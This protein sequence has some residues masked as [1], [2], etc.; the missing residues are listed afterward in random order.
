[1][2]ATVAEYQEVL[3]TEVYVDVDKLRQVSRHGIPTEVRG[4]V[5]K[6]LLR[7]SKPDKSEEISQHKK[8]T[9][10][11]QELDK[12]NN[13]IVKRIKGELKRYQPGV[14][15]FNDD[16]VLLMF[17]KIL[18][19]F[20]NTNSHLEYHPSVVHVLGP[21]VFTLNKETDIY[22]CFSKWISTM[23]DRMTVEGISS[24]VSNF[25]RLFRTTQPELANYFDEE[26]VETSEWIVSW[27]QYL[28]CKE[29]PLQGTLR[30]WDTYF[31]YGQDYYED[32]HPYVCLAILETYSEELLELEHAEIKGFLQHIPDTDIDQI[33]VKADNIREDMAESS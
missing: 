29:L 30:L 2:A 32:L 6:Y 8:M 33:L 14:Q 7:V 1:M 26:E 18:L 5:W 24:H 27:M 28:L 23:M 3:Q 22:F 15:F 13:D 17:E 11:Y 20:F 9:L 16:K 4:E 10:D 25:M 19:A 12:S 21:F 31:A